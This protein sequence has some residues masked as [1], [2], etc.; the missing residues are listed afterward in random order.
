MAKQQ[1]AMLF[2]ASH[3]TGCKGCQVACKQWNM[4]PSPMGL[5]ENKFSGSYQ[6]PPDLNGDTRLVMTFRETPSGNKF[7]PVNMAIG[8]RSCFHC[9]DAG[10]VAICSS[11]ALYKT[12]SGVVAFDSK[13]CNGCTYCQTACPFDVPRFRPTDGTIDKCT[14]CLDRLD[15]GGIPACVKTCQ[16]EALSFGPR[17]EMIAKGMARVEFLKKKGFDKA[18]LY[19]VSE[20]GGL[21]ILTVCQY[22]H[23]AYGLPTNP[24][25]NSM[26]GAMK[27]MKAV[28]GIGTAAVIAGLA[29]SFAAATGYRRKKVTIEEA[30]A[31]W[32]SEQRA[33]ADREVKELLEKEAPRQ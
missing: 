31:T 26:V 24:K 10:C 30:K 29:V 9:T 17:D 2:D 25:T 4:L 21:H 5:N 32:T 7:H 18:E 6:N 19:G 3:C 28:T 22:G 20:M 16:P 14:M 11:G 33:K 15:E 8:R 23:E 13:K 12:E 1:V 27:T